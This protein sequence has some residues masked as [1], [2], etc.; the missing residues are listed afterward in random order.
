[1][2]VAPHHGRESGV[3]SELFDVSNR[4][5]SAGRAPQQ[6]SFGC[7]QVRGVDRVTG[8]ERIAVIG[9]ANPGLT[10]SGTG[11]RWT[12]EPDRLHPVSS[13]R[14]VADCLAQLLLVNGT[15]CPA[16]SQRPGQRLGSYLVS[17]ADTQ[18]ILPN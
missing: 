7:R 16:T 1:M 2:F 10:A 14:T 18:P 9:G 6:Q 15:C 11:S 12:A 17:L 8:Q 4:S 5:S 13:G 3:C